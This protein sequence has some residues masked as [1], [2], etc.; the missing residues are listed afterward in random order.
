LRDDAG[1]YVALL[2]VH[3][4]LAPTRYEEF[5]MAKKSKKRATKKKGSKKKARRKAAKK[6]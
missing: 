2:V 6:M 5:H 4:P 1:A 3:R